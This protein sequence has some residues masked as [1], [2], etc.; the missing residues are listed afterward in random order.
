MK[1]LTYGDKGPRVR[2]L[3]TLLNDNRFHHFRRKLAVDGDMR[4]LTCAAVKNVKY[5]AGYDRED[6]D[7]DLRDQIAGGF[8]FDLLTGKRELPPEYKARRRK[9]LAK[10]AEAA[11]RRPLRLKILVAAEPEV[12]T[13]EGPNN[14]I[15]YNRW[16]CGGGNDG[17][18][19]CVRFGSWCAAEAGCPHVVRGSRWE[20]TDALL[21]D[22]KAGRSGVHVTADP[23]PGNGFVIDWEGHSDPDHFGWYVSDAEGGEFKS[24]EGNATLANGR[25]GVGY[26]FRPAWQCWYI[27]FE[28]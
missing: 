16:W 10:A 4:S 22:A 7:P 13:L 5:W 24:L 14:D 9:R 15:K 12:G 20:N 17:G 19:Y 28:D 23:D 25:Q 21:A 27:V 2:R 18:A 6:M 1:F 8:F 3:Q 26:H 11:K